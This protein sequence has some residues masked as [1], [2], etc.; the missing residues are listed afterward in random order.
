MN[1]ASRCCSKLLCMLSTPTE[2][3]A[4]NENHFECFART[5]VNTPETPSTISRLLSSG[6]SLIFLI[7]GQ[8]KVAIADFIAAR[9]SVNCTLARILICSDS[10]VSTERAAGRKIQICRDFRPLKLLSNHRLWMRRRAPLDLCWSRLSLGDLGNE[11][12]RND[13]LDV[14]RRCSTIA[15]RRGVDGGYGHLGV[16]NDLQDSNRDRDRASRRRAEGQLQNAAA[17]VHGRGVG[18][19]TDASPSRRALL[20]SAPWPAAAPA[21]TSGMTLLPTGASLSC[22]FRMLIS[23]E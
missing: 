2:I 22:G 10:I 15:G 19:K 17:V 9:E 18:R 20:P 12:P 4:I 16:A 6:E 7:L 11:Q 21:R 14:D 23:V 8:Y 13:L 1:F 3:Q 5:G